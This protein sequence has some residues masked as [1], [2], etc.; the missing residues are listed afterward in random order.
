MQ[1]F[2]LVMMVYDL[3]SFPSH[4]SQQCHFKL[5]GFVPNRKTLSKISKMNIFMLH[6]VLFVGQLTP[7]SSHFGSLQ[8]SPLRN[9]FV[10]VPSCKAL[11]SDYSEIACRRHNIPFK[12]SHT[13]LKMRLHI[14][15]GALSSLIWT[16]LYK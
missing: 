8:P 1:V 7:L 15:W 3:Y 6:T 14:I 11:N 4:V 9:P 2:K 12:S 13:L 5:Q 10:I 16:E